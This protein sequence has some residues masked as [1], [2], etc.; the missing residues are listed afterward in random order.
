MLKPDCEARAASAHTLR[1]TSA[2]GDVLASEQVPAGEF[3]SALRRFYNHAIQR[4]NAVIV[5]DG[6]MQTRNSF[7]EFVRAFNDCAA[8]THS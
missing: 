8:R 6:I 1:L 3:P 2:Y 5:L 7:L 4:G